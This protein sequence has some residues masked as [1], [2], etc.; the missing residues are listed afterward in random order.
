MRGKGQCYRDSSIVAGITPAYA[1]KRKHAADVRSV[2]QD[3]PRLCG[4]KFLSCRHK[5]LNVGSPPPMRGKVKYACKEWNRPGITPAYAGKRRK[6]RDSYNGKKDHPRLCGEKNC[7]HTQFQIVIGSP[8]PMRGK[9]LEVCKMK[10]GIRITPAY[11]GKRGV[12][13]TPLCSARDHPRLCGEKNVCRKM[14]AASYGS[15]PPMRG[16]AAEENHFQ[17]SLRITP[18]YAGKSFLSTSRAFCN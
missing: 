7:Q 12:V 13:V 9:V 10:V 6:N 4:E 18:A 11:A 17:N 3:H 5:Y 14:P 1:G 16:K 8:P 15:P 2:E